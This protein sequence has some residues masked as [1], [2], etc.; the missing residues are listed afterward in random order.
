MRVLE[1]KI[2]SIIRTMDLQNGFI[3]EKLETITEN[4]SKMETHIKELDE[5]IQV[6]VI[7]D[8]GHYYRC[9]NTTEIKDLRK[10]IGDTK[11]D[12]LFLTE[13][14][15]FYS[16]NPN[17]LVWTIGGAVALMFIGIISLWMTLSQVKQDVEYK[18]DVQRHPTE[19]L[20]YRGGTIPVAPNSKDDTLTK[21]QKK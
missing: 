5:K 7:S 21:S 2:T 1:E 15:R 20:H 16:R 14:S 19:E 12:L 6:L 10:T 11:Q 13:D 4:Q 9:P 8:N 3:N 17:I 18:L